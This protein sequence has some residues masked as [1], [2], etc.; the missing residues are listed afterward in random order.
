MYEYVA[1]TF[2]GRLIEQYGQHSDYFD[3]RHNW[4]HPIEFNGTLPLVL[5]QLA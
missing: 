3:L 2:C 4:P 5:Q 1:R